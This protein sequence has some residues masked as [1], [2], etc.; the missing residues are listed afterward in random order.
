[1]INPYPNLK[2]SK[3]KPLCLYSFIFFCF[4]SITNLAAQDTLNSDELFINVRTVAF[5]EDAH[6]AYSYLIYWNDDPEK[7]LIV[8]ESGIEKNTESESF[9]KSKNDF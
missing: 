8:I 9:L 5:E 4:L 3:Q 6:L 7:A 1:M 2:F